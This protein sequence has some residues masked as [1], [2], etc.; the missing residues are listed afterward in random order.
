MFLVMQ[1]APSRQRDIKMNKLSKILGALK[2]RAE[3]GLDCTGPFEQGCVFLDMNIWNQDRM[4]MRQYLIA[5]SFIHVV[6]ACVIT[7]R[8][9]NENA[10]S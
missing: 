4:K 2:G 8:T 6:R 9:G 3:A 5:L 1:E 10:I 7:H